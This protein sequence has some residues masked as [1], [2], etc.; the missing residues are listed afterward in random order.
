MGAKLLEISTEEEPNYILVMILL[1]AEVR[2]AIPLSCTFEYYFK[3]MLSS[4][5]TL[6]PVS[7]VR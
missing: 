3:F 6:F 2:N 5:V 7:K 1:I 4:R